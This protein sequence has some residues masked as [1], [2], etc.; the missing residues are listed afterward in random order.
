MADA[1]RAVQRGAYGGCWA[2]AM[3]YVTGVV[4]SNDAVAAPRREA[5]FVGVTLLPGGRRHRRQGAGEPAG[6][7]VGRRRADDERFFA[8][9]RS[10]RQLLGTAPTT[11][12]VGTQQGYCASSA[13]AARRCRDG[14]CVA[15]RAAAARGG[16]G[17]QTARA[18]VA[19]V[20][21]AACARCAMLRVSFHE[22]AITR[23]FR[24]LLLANGVL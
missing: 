7:A 11:Y 8:R 22:W 16:P 5:A 20:S 14:A 6:L 17:R 4:Y 9:R 13:V 23:R 19:I 12:D 18:A 2:R 3:R 24:A 15:A 21:R 10:A 1:E